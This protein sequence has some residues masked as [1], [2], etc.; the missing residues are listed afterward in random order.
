M[1]NKERIFFNG[2][3]VDSRK[4]ELQEKVGTNK[5]S[6]SSATFSWV[7]KQEVDTNAR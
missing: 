2:G 7:A 6:G 5:P 4:G 3:L 1:T